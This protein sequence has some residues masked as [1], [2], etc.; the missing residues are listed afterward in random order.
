[1]FWKSWLNKKKPDEKYVLAG[2][3]Q[4]FVFIWYKKMQIGSTTFFTQKFRQK[5]QAE[6]IEEAKEKLTQFVAKKMQLCIVEESGFE[7][8]DLAKM[9]DKLAYVEAAID[10]LF[11]NDKAL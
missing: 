8:T 9:E 1:M 5:V 2:K 6:N 7:K 3:G 4:E 10:N 11:K